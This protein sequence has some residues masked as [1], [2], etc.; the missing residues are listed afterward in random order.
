MERPDVRRFDFNPLAM[1]KQRRSDMVRAAL[2]LM[3]AYQDSGAEPAQGAMASFETW[4]RLVRQTVCWLAEQ[5][6]DFGLTDPLEAITGAYA[7]D[8]ERLRLSA[9]LQAWRV[10]FDDKWKTLVDVRRDVQNAGNGAAASAAESQAGPAA[11]AGQVDTSASTPGR[12]PDTGDHRATCRHL[13]GS[14]EPGR[15]MV[16]LHCG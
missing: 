13:R 4:D 14:R 6:P 16:R 12:K 15:P 5:F 10:Q 8:P 11:S 1:V 9:V 3:K 2:M 7:V